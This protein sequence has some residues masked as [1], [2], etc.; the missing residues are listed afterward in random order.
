[1]EIE[2]KRERS[3]RRQFE[4]IVYNVKVSWFFD[5]FLSIV[6]LFIKQKLERYRR[7]RH[8]I[9][10]PEYNDSLTSISHHQNPELYSV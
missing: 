1:M 4:Y 6:S 7:Q 8:R 10:S 2:R 5:I 3:L 9:R